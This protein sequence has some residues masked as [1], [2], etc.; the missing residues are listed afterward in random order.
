MF[1]LISYGIAITVNPNLAAWVEVM[2]HF[3]V[4]VRTGAIKCNSL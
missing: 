4:D 3:T 1:L 2:I